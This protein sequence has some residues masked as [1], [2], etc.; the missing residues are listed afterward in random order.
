MNA[1]RL[2]RLN[3]ADIGKIR[4]DAHDF[5][6]MHAGR[7][8]VGDELSQTQMARQA[9]DRVV[10]GRD[11]LHMAAGGDHEIGIGVACGE[12][13]EM[14]E[15]LGKR[16]LGQLFIAHGSNLPLSGYRPAS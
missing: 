14:G 10:T 13:F 15:L 8:L 7:R 16:R 6:E 9:R 1:D 11:G 12:R 4:L 2:A 3:G 5:T